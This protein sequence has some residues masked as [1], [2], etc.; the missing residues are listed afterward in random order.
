M[1]VKEDFQKHQK[2]LPPALNLRSHDQASPAANENRSRSPSPVAVV[3]PMFQKPKPQSPYRRQASVGP[4]MAEVLPLAQPI[5]PTLLR[6]HYNQQQQQ[7]Q[8]IINIGD[9]YN[10]Q[11]M[12]NCKTLKHEECNDRP[13]DPNL[14]CPTCKQQFRIGEIQEYKKHYKLYH[15]GNKKE[16]SDPIGHNV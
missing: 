16:D 8:N 1:L 10:P 14:V 9:T 15:S 3:K 2:K 13:F 12:D 6:V 4:I 7:K 5:S 11:E